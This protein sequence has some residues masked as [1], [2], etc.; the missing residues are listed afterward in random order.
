MRPGGWCRR[1]PQ[2]LTLTYAVI[3]SVLRPLLSR[4]GLGS[5]LLSLLSFLLP[6]ILPRILLPWILPRILL[7]WILPGSCYHGYSPDLVTMDTPPDLVTMDT[8]RILLPWILLGSCYHGSSPDPAGALYITRYNSGLE[9]SKEK[10]AYSL[11]LVGKNVCK[12]GG[13]F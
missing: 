7:P 10:S 5:R 11:A 9:N 13:G 12:E 1:E 3:L 2:V 4:L 6:W 8:P